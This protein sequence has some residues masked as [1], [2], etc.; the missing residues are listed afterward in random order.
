[1]RQGNA[2]IWEG[3]GSEFVS[4]R[5]VGSC[6]R[7]TYS[8][9]S[10]MIAGLKFTCVFCGYNDVGFC[11][12]SI[13]NSDRDSTSIISHNQYP[14]IPTVLPQSKG[15]PQ[16]V[17]LQSEILLFRFVTHG[18]SMSLESRQF[19]IRPI[20]ILTLGRHGLTGI[21]RRPQTPRTPRK[22]VHRIRIIV[23]ALVKSERS[24]NW[25]RARLATPIVSGQEVQTGVHGSLPGRGVRGGKR[26]RIA[27]L[28]VAGGF[29]VVARVRWVGMVGSI[30]VL[31]I[32]Q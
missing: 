22:A 14:S 5:K 31:R 9:D 23:L 4:R 13:S 18:A 27:A 28:V 1:M 12:I 6:S 2:D 24:A 7:V 15:N 20:L 8:V 17:E 10:E 3:C 30:A 29:G 25:R 11:S 32:G 21:D 19:S 16:I 26:R